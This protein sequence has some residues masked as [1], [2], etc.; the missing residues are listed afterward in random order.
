MAR[1]KAAA[2]VAALLLTIIVTAKPLLAAP[3]TEIDLTQSALDFASAN[4]TY[5]PW[6]LS[7]LTF[8]RSVPGSTYGAEIDYGSVQDAS[9]ASRGTFADVNDTRTWSDSFYTFVSVGAGTANPYPTLSAYVEANFKTL[10]SRRL[11]LSLGLGSNHYGSGYGEQFLS[12]GGEY[13][14]PK[15][16]AG[17]RALVAENTSSPTV[18]GALATFEYD[19]STRRSVIGTLQLGPQNYLSAA[20]ALP[21]SRASYQGYAATLTVKQKISHSMGVALGGVFEQEYDDAG[22]KLPV[23]T[24]RGLTFGVYLVQ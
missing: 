24:A 13:Y 22:T 23:F 9:G 17:L 19:P 11:V 5:G 6:H 16:V 15:F 8:L 1:M 2:L 3:S 4:D 12:A 21:P 10:P 18:V 7:S 20:P 14:W